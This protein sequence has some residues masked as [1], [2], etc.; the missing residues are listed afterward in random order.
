MLRY[1][2][3]ALR[4]LFANHTPHRSGAENALLRLLEG[5]PSEHPRA[6]ACP[7]PGALASAL[8][9]RAISQ[10]SVPET[11]ISLRLHPIHTPL[12]L[13]RMTAAAVA[14]RHT[15]RDFR[16][17]L[18]HANSLRA[19]LIALA[20][21][22]LDGPP[23]VVQSH[24]HLPPGRVSQLTRRAVARGAGAVIAVTDRTRANFDAGLPE[25][26]A[27]RVYISVDHVRF[28]PDAAPFPDVRAELGLPPGTPLIGEV[29]QITPWKG[30]DVAIAALAEARRNV[31]AHLLIVGEV[32]FTSRRY[33]NEAYRRS[34]EDQVARLGLQRTVHFL[35]HRD[36]IPGLMHALDI[37][38]LPSRDE[39]F[40]TVAAEA[41]AMGTPAFVSA[42]GGASE[43]VEDRVNGRILPRDDARAWGAA[44]CELVT[45]PETGRRMG[46]EARRTAQRFNDETY[47]AEVLAVYERVLSAAAR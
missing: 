4:L 31:D 44:V 37:L 27:E 8:A 40:G 21:T 24:D 41:M 34:L 2:A 1:V 23:V 29:A 19:G 43:Y 11:D 15:I 39:P 42:E 36:D 18:V 46:V 3:V 12:G 35:G 17:D 13:A 28:S 45:D 22:S 26:V 14:L 47:S 6:V 10:Y 7:A 32:A 9:E 30:Q 16:A 25:P 20:A 5:L 38:L 33:D